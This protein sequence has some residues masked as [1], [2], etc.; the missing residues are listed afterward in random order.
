M[1]EPKE[2]KKNKKN[3]KNMKVMFW[4]TWLYKSKKGVEGE[5]AVLVMQKTLTKWQ[6]NAIFSLSYCVKKQK[7][8]L[9]N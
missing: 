7:Q 8:C 4:P 6:E 2:A 1:G 9:L 5:M 3:K